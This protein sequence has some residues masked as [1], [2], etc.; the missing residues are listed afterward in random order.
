[1]NVT[2]E[3]I[4][5]HISQEKEIGLGSL[6]IGEEFLRCFSG[7][8]VHTTSSLLGLM[9]RQRRGKSLSMGRRVRA[10]RSS[11]LP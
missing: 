11:K 8:V 4:S 9:R 7:C 2:L 3:V 1:V 10:G 6:L 5:E